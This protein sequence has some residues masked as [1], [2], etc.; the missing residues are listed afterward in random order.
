MPTAW[1][2]SICRS[3]SV[4]PPTRSRH[5]GLSPIVPL[6][7]DPLP[8]AR[9][10]PLIS[11]PWALGIG[12]W[13]LVGI[14]EGSPLTNQSPVTNH[15]NPQSPIPNPESPLS[16]LSGRRNTAPR[17]QYLGDLGDVELPL[18]PFH[19]ECQKRDEV[20]ERAGAAGDGDG[21]H[22]RRQRVT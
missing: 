10:I 4:L 6:R 16:A 14:G 17:P 9:M 12:D 8:A 15:P 1:S 2:A 13:G 18:I 21:V 5:F 20:S 11:P 3:T 22:P 19:S 7:R